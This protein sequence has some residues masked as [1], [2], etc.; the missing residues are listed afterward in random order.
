MDIHSNIPNRH[1]NYD[2][3]SYFRLAFIEVRKTVENATA[4]GFRLN[5]SSSVLKFSALN[6]RGG[7]VV[8]RV[9]HDHDLEDL[10]SNSITVLASLLREFIHSCSGCSRC[11]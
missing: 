7:S 11:A 6:V 1:A 4:D 8:A 3:S 2:V 10:G 5:F 9:I